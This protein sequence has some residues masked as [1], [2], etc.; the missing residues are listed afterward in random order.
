MAD[1]SGEIEVAAEVLGE[2]QRPLVSLSVSAGRIVVSGEKTLRMQRVGLL[3]NLLAPLH[4]WWIVMVRG[5][6]WLWCGAQAVSLKNSDSLQLHIVHPMQLRLVV[7]PTSAE[8]S[9]VELRV[10]WGAGRA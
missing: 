6:G 1:G 2:R 4:N 9:L 7:R 10:L 3:G 8:V 5:E